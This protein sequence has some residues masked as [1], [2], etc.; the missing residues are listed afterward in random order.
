[1]FHLYAAVPV[2]VKLLATFK[3]FTEVDPDVH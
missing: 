2:T 3:D 1:M